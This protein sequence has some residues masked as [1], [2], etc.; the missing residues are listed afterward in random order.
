MTHRPSCPGQA[1]YRR[2]L[3]SGDG[4]NVGTSGQ[5]SQIRFNF[6]D[7][8]YIDQVTQVSLIDYSIPNTAYIVNSRNNKVYFETDADGALTATIANGDYTGTTLATELSTK[9][10]L[11]SSSAITV[12]YSSSTGKLSFVIAAGTLRVKFA[13]N[14]TYSARKLLGFNAEDT[15]AA[16]SFDSTN[17]IDLSTFKHYFINIK[18]LPMANKSV[19]TNIDERNGD[20]VIPIESSFLE[21]DYRGNSEIQII[22]LDGY[23]HFHYLTVEI[24]DQDGNYVDF[25][26][27][28]WILHLEFAEMAYHS[29]CPCY[30]GPPDSKRFKCC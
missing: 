28:H 7:F 1:P 2:I 22:R 9:M 16:A 29:K 25:N 10:S 26:G 3:Y 24:K 8:E 5:N 20:F 17:I 14:T 18:E 11:L 12:T 6:R 13:T 23:R 21:F 4:T 27:A 15:T 30:Q 19:Q